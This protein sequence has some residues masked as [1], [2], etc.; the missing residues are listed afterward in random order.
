[1]LL[2][3]HHRTFYYQ[4]LCKLN[5]RIIF[6]DLDYQN[7]RQYLKGF[8]GEYAFFEYIKDFKQLV[9]IWDLTLDIF[10]TAQYDFIF[11]ANDTLIHIDI[12][13]Y[14]GLYRF[15]NGNFISQ[16][17]YVHQGLLSQLDRAHRKLEQ[18]IKLHTFE[19]NVSSRIL[20]V[21]PEF[22]LKGYNGN[23]KIV[24]FNQMTDVISYL[25]TLVSNDVDLKLGLLLVD[26]HVEKEYNRVHYYDYEFIEKGVKCLKCGSFGMFEEKS[27]RTMKCICG[28]QVGKK[29]YIIEAIEDINLFKNGSFT[30][31]E[32]EE[33]TGVNGATLKRYLSVYCNKIGSTKSARYQYKK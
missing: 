18:F 4:Y 5:G 11:V 32:L 17:G 22:K 27:Q 7:L 30:R 33:Y 20:F 1:M 21:N 12:K 2:K 26:H 10:G 13:N 24:F 31:K 19:Y 15:D 28:H 3:R 25:K 23:E 29:E 9:R 16:K 14:T 8:E 6:E